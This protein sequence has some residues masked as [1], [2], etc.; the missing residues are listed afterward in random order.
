MD[1]RK[2]FAQASP[3]ILIGITSALY[4]II[5]IIKTIIRETLRE[6]SGGKE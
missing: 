5:K 6:L 4:F 2:M 3:K 1:V